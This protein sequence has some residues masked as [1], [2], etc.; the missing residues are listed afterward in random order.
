VWRQH[1]AGRVGRFLERQGL[2]EGDR[3]CPCLSY[4]SLD[5]EPMQALLA[6]S[7]THR[8]AVGTCATLAHSGC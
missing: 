2:L 3:E 7:I 4:L 1:I 6:H 8:I 5:E